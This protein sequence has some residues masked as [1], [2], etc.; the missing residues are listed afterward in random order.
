MHIP[1]KGSKDRKV[2]ETVFFA[3]LASLRAKILYAVTK[4]HPPHRD[5]L[6]QLRSL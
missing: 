1:R 2:K 4:N 5:H 3:P 6:F